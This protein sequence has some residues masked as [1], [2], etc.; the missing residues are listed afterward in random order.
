VLLKTL[1]ERPGE[2]LSQIEA[3]GAVRVEGH[4][5]GTLNGLNFAPERGGTDLENRTLRSVVD[6]AVAPEIVRRLN[7]LA[8]D[9]HEAF[10]MDWDGLLRWRGHAVGEV[11]GGGPFRPTARLLADLGADASRARAA[12]RLEAFVAKEARRLLF[13]LVRIEDAMKENRIAGAARG[14]A[15]QLVER[16]GIIDRSTAIDQIRAL[17]RGDRAQLQDL[18]VHFGVFSLYLPGL[19]RPEARA[20]GEIFAGLSVRGWRAPAEGLTELPRPRPPHEALSLRGLREV[21]GFAAPVLALERLG[22][23][24]RGAEVSEGGLEISPELTS[25][26]GWTASQT[27]A[28]LRALGF[29]RAAAEPGKAS[30]LWRR[31]NAGPENREPATSRQRRR[32]ERPARAVPDEAAPA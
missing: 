15:Y 9:G 30:S 1:H 3:D 24:A 8:G 12:R 6:R 26:F 20:F 29:S 2:I 5:V 19:W 13:P 28:I 18:G 27:E 22:G 31:R 10:A 25:A 21:A 32:R 14:L 7:E 17:D 23:L 11:T 4:L 16:Y